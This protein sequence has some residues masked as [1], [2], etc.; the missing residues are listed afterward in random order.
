VSSSARR[1]RGFG[2]S[3]LAAS[4]SGRPPAAFATA[5]AL[6]LAA[7]VSS[8]AEPDEPERSTA[9][10]QPSGGPVREGFE[11]TELGE[12]PS[13]WIRAGLG[14]RTLGVTDQ[15]AARGSRALQIEVPAGQGP[16]GGM[17]SRGGLGDLAEAHFGRVFLRIQGPGVSQFVHFDAFEG[18]GNWEG[19][20]NAVRWASTGTGAGTQ[21][22]N[23]SWIY[24]VQRTQ[25]GE[26]GTERDR[27]AH[28]RVDEW[29]CLEWRFDAAVQE[30]Q[31][32][33]DGAAVEYLTLSQSAGDRTEIPAFS[34]L[35]VG[36][37][38]FQQTDAFVVWIDEVAFDLERI[39]CDG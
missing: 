18:R 36:F 25:G 7:C 5:A 9:D 27:S 11:D 38:K 16:A 1:A 17:L 32:W 13:Q 6:L 22:G 2:F 26:F 34:S 10:A 21:P 35:S 39:G 33:L 3:P 14:Q 28:P 4:G 8:D 19:Q 29:M 30:A 15:Q 31:F 23:W 12:I 20:V 37:Q 24:N